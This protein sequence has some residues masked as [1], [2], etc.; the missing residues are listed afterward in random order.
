VAVTP[1]SSATGFNLKDFYD[2]AYSQNWIGTAP[3]IYQVGYGF[4]LVSTN[5][6]N[7]GFVM[8]NFAMHDAF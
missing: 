7:G 1:F 3:R 5:H 4:E 8:F 2:Y 6:Y